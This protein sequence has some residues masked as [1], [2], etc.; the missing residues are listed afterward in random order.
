MGDNTLFFDDS[1]MDQNLAPD[2]HAISFAG[3]L[4]SQGLITA[5]D[6]I[7]AMLHIGEDPAIDPGMNPDP[8]SCTLGAVLPP[9]PS[10][11]QRF[12]AASSLVGFR[13]E[14]DHRIAQIETFYSEPSKVLPR[15]E[16]GGTGQ[17][18]ENPA[19]SLLTCGNNLIDIIQTLTPAAQSPPQIESALSTEVVLLALSSYLAFMRLLD[20]LF[21][22]IRRH[23]CLAPRESWRSVKVKSVLRIGGF[24]TLQDMPL[25][26][27]GIGV[28]DAIKCQVQTV[29]RLM[30]IPAGYR[31]WGETNASPALPS[32]DPAGILS[33]ADRARLFLAAVDQEDVRSQHGSKSYVESIRT[34][35]KESFAL[36]D[37]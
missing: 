5:D 26:A 15:C 30:G 28:L 12:S 27:Y 7:D 17:N 11:S 6:D 3:Y 36:L 9:T 29:E 21:H 31:L 13:E 25:K 18:V 19:E 22:R 2:E 34:N 10:V 24:S 32:A 33:R 20:T 37:G 14:T 8:V 16:D 35:I 1:S 4:N 23:I